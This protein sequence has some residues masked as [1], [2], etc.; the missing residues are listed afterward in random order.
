MQC[1][2]DNSPGCARAC[3]DSQVYCELGQYQSLAYLDPLGSLLDGCLTDEAAMAAATPPFMCGAVLL[4]LVLDS[5]TCQVRSWSCLR[6]QVWGVCWCAA[7]KSGPTPHHRSRHV[8]AVIAAGCVQQGHTPHPQP[9]AGE[10]AHARTARPA[11]AAAARPQA[12][13]G[14]AA[15]LPLR[16]LWAAL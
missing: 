4:P 8:V 6:G 16:D 14:A 12:A 1:A 10:L 7:A 2:P 5:L 13:A 11:T 9:A 15:A 3:C